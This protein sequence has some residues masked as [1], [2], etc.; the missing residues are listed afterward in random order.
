LETGILKETG[1]HCFT[2]PTLSYEEEDSCMS[3]EEEDTC[4]SYEEEDTCMSYEE[5]D[6]CMSYEEEDT[7]MSYEE[8]DTYLVD[9]PNLPE[10]DLVVH[11]A[12][13]PVNA[14]QREDRV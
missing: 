14:G 4:M 1:C 8:E 7:C 10:V 6:T 2:C 13:C 5:E 3:Y 9:M 11:M 12:S